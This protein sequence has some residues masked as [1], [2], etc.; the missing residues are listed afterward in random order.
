[1]EAGTP[2]KEDIEKQL[3]A[4]YTSQFERFY[5]TVHP[6]GLPGDIPG[7]CSNLNYAARMAVK[8]LKE[9]RAYNFKNVEV[10]VTT[11]DVDNIFGDRYFDALEEDYWKLTPDQRYNTVWQSPL[12]YCMNIDKSPFFVRNIGLLRAFF[13]MGYLIPWNI[14]TMSVFSLTLKLYEDGEF[15]HPGYQG[16]TIFTSS[17]NGPD[18]FEDGL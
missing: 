16:P 18:K 13:M 1:M 4:K 3:K 2:N 8:Y 10:L 12:F 17:T 11:G 15:T 5:I 6:K 9:D 14:N 7:K